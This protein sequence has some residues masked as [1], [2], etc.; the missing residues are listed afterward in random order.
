MPRGACDHPPRGVRTERSSRRVP[1][2][3]RTP[4]RRRARPPLP[5]P[6]YA[7]PYATEMALESQSI[8]RCGAALRTCLKPSWRHE[9]LMLHAA[10]PGCSGDPPRHALRMS[11]SGACRSRLKNE[12]TYAPKSP[13]QGSSS[14]CA[15][16]GGGNVRSSGG[17]ASS[18]CSGHGAQQSL[19]ANPAGELATTAF[20]TDD[21][22]THLSVCSQHHVQQEL[23]VRPLDSRY[24]LRAL[25]VSRLLRG[26]VCSSSP[27]AGRPAGVH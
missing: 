2:V 9:P 15:R 10:C 19:P 5:M 3:R 24:K 7:N 16:A 23:A 25:R 26:A 21:L 4:R 12:C 22:P 20:C 8:P 18:P 17:E 11:A 27:G 6:V 14:G 13:L 1:R